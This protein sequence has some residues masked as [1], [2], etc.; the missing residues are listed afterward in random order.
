ML[1]RS[2]RSK[3]LYLAQLS[4][5]AIAF[6]GRINSSRPR[7]GTACRFACLFAPLRQD[8][9]LDDGIRKL[10][11]RGHL[12]ERAHLF[13]RN[14]DQRCGRPH[15]PVLEEK[16]GVRNEPL[17]VGQEV[18]RCDHSMIVARRSDRRA[19]T[20]QSRVL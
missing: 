13:E 5:E 15:A 1:C 8:V 11:R 12:D 17:C 7:T 20:P 16:V 4:Y 2:V 10:G 9:H 6:I 18:G 3:A 19:L 14:D